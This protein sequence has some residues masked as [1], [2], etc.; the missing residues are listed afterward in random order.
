MAKLPDLREEL[1]FYGVSVQ[2]NCKGVHWIFRQ[3]RGVAPVVVAEYWP[4]TRK[5]TMAGVRKPQIVPDVERMA[6][7]L[8]AK[9]PMVAVA[10]AVA[11]I[12]DEVTLVALLSLLGPDRFRRAV[13]LCRE[14]SDDLVD[15]VVA[16]FE[17]GL[18][19]A[20]NN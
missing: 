12:T 2:V 1:S 16:A 3:Q 15:A 9:L 11:G 10:S 6:S 8:K 17:A 14:A 19:Q 13:S 7:L 18:R 20:G 5:L 4:T